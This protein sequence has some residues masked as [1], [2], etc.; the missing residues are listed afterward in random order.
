MK[1]LLIHDYC[2]LDG[3]AEAGTRTLQRGLKEI[4]IEARVFAA[5]TGTNEIADH[6]C[7]GTKGSFRTLLQ[8]ANPSAW[9]E[10]RKLLREWKPDVVHVRMFLTQLSPLIL[11]LLKEFPCLYHAVWYRAICPT[12]TKVL[13]GGRECDKP[14]G[15][16]CLEHGCLPL[17]DWP[18]LMVQMRM[19]AA[20]RSSFDAVV[21]NS[22]AVK[23]KLEEAGIAPVEVI[24]NGVPVG[25]EPVA[26]T[27][28]PLAVFAGR[29]V[30]EKGVDVLLRAF[31]QVPE[32]RLILA[33]SGPEEQNL[34]ALAIE[35]G[36]GNRVTFDGQLAPEAL[37]RRFAGAWVQVIPSQ[38]AEPFGIVAAEAMM[39]GAAVIAS[40]VGGLPEVVEHGE[41]GILVPPANVDAWA[42]ALAST[43]GNRDQCERMGAAGRERALRLFSEAT[44]V[45]QFAKLYE[46]LRQKKRR[47]AV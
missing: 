44:W 31:A 19:L 25:D 8:T 4:G 7:F 34:K 38:W 12:G 41:T 35:L 15:L 18:V 46:N 13:P 6:L 47:D 45:A 43:L 37:R 27:T 26:M 29:L 33:G 30:K 40:H 5:N 39:R 3:G 20:W 24:W 2:S 11:P 36:V 23:A 32:G 42:Q 28:K 16:A 22:N 1:V 9:L 17:W 10:L 21:V 14:A